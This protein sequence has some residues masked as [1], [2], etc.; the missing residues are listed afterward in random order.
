MGNYS[1]PEN[2]RKMKPQGTMVKKIKNGYY[3]YNYTSQQIVVED[4]HGNKRRKTK[5]VMGECI[6]SITEKDGYIPNAGHISNSIITGRNY[7]NY[8][9]VL[10]HSSDTY[11]KLCSIFHPNDAK[12]I[13]SAAV[14]FFVEGFTYMTAMKGEY[15]LSYLPLVY[16]N[17][18]MGYDALHTLYT[19]L[20]TR[21]T[22]IREFESMLIDNSSKQIA[23][24]G[25]VIACTS[26][27]N[28]LSEFGYKASK[29]GTEQINWLTA[30]D[31]VDGLPLF[32]YV[33]SGAD[34]DKVSVKSL[35]R[36]YEFSNTE[37][38]VDRGF[39]TAS[40]KQLMAS[41]GNTYIVPMISNRDDY[42]SVIEN[43]K[44]DKRRY[45]VFNKNGYASMI[46]YAEY[47]AA[48]DSCRYFAYQDT[49]RAGAERQAYI[50]A[51]SLGKREY[52]EAGL[53]ENELY[54]GLFLLETNNF[55]LDAETVFCHYKSRWSIE[56]YYN[57]VR[58]D[59]DFNALYQQDFFCMQGVSFIVTVAGMIYHD[60]KKIADRAKVSVKEIMREMKKL[61]IA[62]EGDKWVVQN[63]IKC[64]RELADKIGFDIPKYI[65]V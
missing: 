33:Y 22:K 60:I 56:T 9:V 12:Q 26:E 49:T 39:N 30:Y 20:G 46:Y 25:H 48:D 34:P 57:Y 4:E 31:V 10:K 61:K 58:N 17:V 37:F 40:A 50:K 44:F 55:A 63:K 5:T 43:L 8:A 13:Y 38:L 36:R 2:I 15:E 7:G 32:S 27:Y 19:N 6:G 54:F 47:R 35:I 24:D 16:D 28:D 1:V 23:I 52:S 53:I 45:F 62:L 41:N 42:A 21:D 11:S 29:L 64:V 3:V 65:T 59:V 14:I 51:M 18:H